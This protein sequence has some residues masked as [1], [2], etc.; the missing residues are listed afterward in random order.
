M[1]SDAPTKNFG[2][3]SRKPVASGAD[4]TFPFLLSPIHV[5][6]HQLR[7]RVMMGSMH[8]RLEMMERSIERLALF[9]G[10]RASGGAGLIVTGGY[11]P[12]LEGLLDEKGPALLTQE[13]ADILKP[14]PQAVHDAGGKIILQ[15]LHTGRNAK[16]KQPVGASAIPS[17]I[18]PKVPR[19]LSTEEV[20]ATIEDFVHCAE[21]A[22][23]AGFDGVEIMGSEGY[24]LNQFTVIRTNNRDDEFGGSLENRL[25]LPLEIVRRTR[26]R[27]GRSFLIM[28]RISAIDLVEGGAPLNEI[29]TL[30]QAVEQAGADIL[31]TG[32]GWHESR[33]PTIGYVVPRAAWRFAVARI[34][35]VVG[36]PIIASNRINNPAIAEELL[37][38]EDADMVS[39]ARPFL[40]DPDFVNKAATGRAD[41]INTCI[42][43][44][45]ACLDYI[46]SERTASCL[47][48]PK[49]GNELEY[50]VLL[51]RKSAT[52]KVGIIGAGAAG[53]AC[54]IT[55][56]ERG[57]KVTL[58]EASS[59]IG[60]QLNLARKVP[61]KQE[62]DALIK[63]YRIKLD[64]LGIQVKLNCSVD[65]NYLF[66]QQFDH[67]VIATG[68][69]PR[70]V[71]IPGSDKLKVVNYVD[72]LSGLVTAGQKVIVMGAGGVGFDV[73]QF[74][75]G[76]KVELSESYDAKSIAHFQ[77]EWGVDPSEN[78]IGGIKKSLPQIISREVTIVQRKPEKM[79]RRLGMT[80]GWAIKSELSRRNVQMLSG[81]TYE[82]IDEQGL[83]LTINGIPQLL[84][85]DTIVICAGQD[86][87]FDLH[88][89]LKRLGVF[90]NVIGGA[91]QAQEL[92]ALRA[93]DQGT[94]LALSF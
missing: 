36:I 70:Q 17:P 65:A 83:H 45:Q 94:R 21:L 87:V 90:S 53:L 86:S 77:E 61:G 48:N 11:A 19:A 80:T 79:G 51:D 12:N 42:A 14:I 18:N 6:S 8:T 30:A 81:C 37:S 76:E 34:R 1:S 68:V 69:L 82:R 26:E 84:K 3:V 10:S 25:R 38:S 89:D 13:D 24:L 4:T 63:Y 75:V 59:D 66:K 91:E 28:Y 23:R 56:A 74:L 5:G 78:S 55:A 27:L 64:V 9:Y 67:Y 39:M 92:D 44:N 71:E 29:L 57:H 93:I 41:E 15:V 62:F 35:K 85:A 20:W 72:L 7:N 16:V 54:A 52:K 22:Q 88:L 2:L 32:I 58:F 46:F 33:V 73:A 31:N 40:A 50:A 60:G 47:V 49:A 43:C